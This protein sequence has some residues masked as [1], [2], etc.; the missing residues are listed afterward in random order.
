MR[1]HPNDVCAARRF[2]KMKSEFRRMVRAEKRKVRRDLAA[3]A[4][5]DP[6]KIL[7][8]LNK[9][10]VIPSVLN[11]AVDSKAS[12]AFLFSTFFPKIKSSR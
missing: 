10:V 11:G 3:Q 7:R 8:R 12:T 9:K 4:K 1:K 5:K 2:K 6:W